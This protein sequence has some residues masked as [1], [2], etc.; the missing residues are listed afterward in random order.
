M[1]WSG[2]ARAGKVVGGIAALGILVWTVRSAWTE[3]RSQEIGFDAGRAALATG[4]LAITY[5]GFA[6]LWREIALSLG[7]KVPFRNT[8]QLWSFSNLGR[9]LPGKV[10]QVIGLV[11]IARDLGVPPGVA[12]SVAII[13]LGFMICSGALVGVLLVPGA[14]AEYPVLRAGIWAIALGMVVPLASP[15]ILARAIRLLPES[16]GCR[17]VRGFSRLT[18]VKLEAY[19]LATWLVH[20]ATFLVLASAFA[21]LGWG[22]F[23]ALCGSFSLSYVGGLI[24]VFA[25]GG[26]G[27]REGLIVVLLGDNLGSDVP[28]HAIA[29]GARVWTLLGE[30]LVLLLALGLRFRTTHGPRSSR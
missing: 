13:A 23:P 30:L 25:P 22:A 24:A 16:F 15:G 19:F 4:L 6:G 10:W 12:T 1:K 7:T 5:L 8:V 21:P 14:A 9:Y 3:L 18:V 29:V 26:I 20:G 17:D 2:V 27:V 28:V 11:V